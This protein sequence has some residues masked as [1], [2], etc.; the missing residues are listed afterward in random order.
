MVVKIR[1][2]YQEYL[3]PN[4]QGVQTVLRTM[5]KAL[6]VRSDNRYRGGEIELDNSEPL[7]VEMEMLPDIKIVSR[8][9]SSGDEV[10]EPEVVRPRQLTGRR[11]LNP[12]SSNRSR[13]LKD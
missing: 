11:G 6:R 2:G 9:R 12:T 3:L 5:S 7:R 10:L 1:I 4:D 8:K 13:L